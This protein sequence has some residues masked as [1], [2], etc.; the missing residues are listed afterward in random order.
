[1]SSTEIAVSKSQALADLNDKLGALEKQAHSLAV[2]DQSSYIIGA[3]LLTSLKAVVQAVEFQT[4]PRLAA[5]KEEFERAKQEQ[6]AFLNPAKKILETIKEK[7]NVFREEEK[8][9]AKIEE[10]RKNAEL[11]RQAQEKAET[12]RKESERIA[13]ENRKRLVQEIMRDLDAGKIGKREASRLMKLAGANEEAAKQEA[14]AREE[15]AKNAPPPQIEVKPSIPKVAGA[16]RNQTFYFG[17]VEEP[18]AII[19]AYEGALID[20][21]PRRAAFLARFIMVNEQEV[22]AFAREMKDSEKA[23]A[24]VPGVRFYS[25]G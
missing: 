6:A 18:Q 1:M 9:Q 21:N 20:N 2:K 25:K 23:Q 13:A 8:R 19:A 22:G 3:G 17:T 14:A 7:M 11:R 24:L 4:G 10:D 15:E 5:A 12:D 16:P